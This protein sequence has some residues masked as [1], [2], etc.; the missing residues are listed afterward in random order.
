M[1]DFLKTILNL[2][3]HYP[4]L[5]WTK[6]DEGAMHSLDILFVPFTNVFFFFFIESKDVGAV[7]VF[8]CIQFICVTNEVV[9]R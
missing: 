9:Q 8:Q 3:H 5:K 2:T 6:F 1:N 4:V 7:K